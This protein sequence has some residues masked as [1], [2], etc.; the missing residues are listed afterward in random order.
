MKMLEGL[1]PKSRQ[2]VSVYLPDSLKVL[3][4]GAAAE[5]N[6]FTKEA[7]VLLE[8]RISTENFVPSFV[9]RQQEKERGQGQNDE[10]MLEDIKNNQEEEEDGIEKVGQLDN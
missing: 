1:S 2:L 4:L 6:G 8:Q 3:V 10:A 5:N 7:S 9:K